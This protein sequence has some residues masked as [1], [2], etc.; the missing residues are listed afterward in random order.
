MTDFVST[1]N[2]SLPAKF[3]N[4]FK[5]RDIFLHDGRSL[6]RI[7]LGAPI[8]MAVAFTLVALLA[9]SA[10]ATVR[11]VATADVTQMEQQI[12]QMER[13]VARMRAQTQSHAALLE[14]RQAFLAQVLSGDA[15]PDELAALL[16]TGERLPVNP[17]SRSY[18]QVDVE[19]LALAERARHVTAQRYQETAGLV[20]R[21]GLDPARFHRGHQGVGGPLEAVESDNADPRFRE[22]FV[23]WQRLDQLEQ[24][25][26]AI[27]SAHPVRSSANFTS[28]FGVRSDPFRGRAAMHGGIDLAGPVGT[29]IYATADGVIAKSEYNN[30]G[31]GNLV[32]IN[33]GK[34][35]QTRYAHL[36]RRIARPG[37]QVRRGDLIGLMGSTG[38]STGS[39]L[40]YEVRIDGRAVNPTPF[41][42]S[43]NVL[44]A[45]QNRSETANVAQGG[46]NGGSR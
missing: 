32:E 34:G 28:G 9:W 29:P 11:A 7:T 5:P 21:L 10:F 15:D 4:L 40:H 22:L 36:S 13:D 42:Q 41:M 25:V 3:R 33:H 45:L 37:Q 18:A 35:I 26:S 23:S 17:L 8:Q 38:R 43:G 2:A 30:G 12:A 6:R 20:R 16:P 31:Y 14:R 1:T 27:P 19:Q 46:P 39:H 24:G 44:L